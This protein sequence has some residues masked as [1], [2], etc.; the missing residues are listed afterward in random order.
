MQASETVIDPK[1]RAQV[2][3]YEAFQADGW[4]KVDQV[5]KEFQ[6]DPVKLILSIYANPDF[7]KTTASFGEKK[8]NR[9]V[10]PGNGAEL[11][12]LAQLML[13]QQTTVDAGV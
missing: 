9:W 5:M 10:G 1:V 6:A 13:M 2:L 11:A 7:W 12:Y 8:P 3:L 4:E